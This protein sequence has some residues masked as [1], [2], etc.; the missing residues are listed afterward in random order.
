[1]L[2]AQLVVFDLNINSR[3]YGL[4]SIS[5]G[6]VNA[7]R[8]L[9][10]SHF[11]SSSIYVFDNATL[12]FEYLRAIKIGNSLLWESIMRLTIVIIRT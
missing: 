7:V 4:S 2:Q 10:E 8:I 9:D 12:I 11:E 3:K 6:H 1:M 5:K